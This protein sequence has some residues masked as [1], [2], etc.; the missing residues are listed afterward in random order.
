MKLK[1]Y[2]MMKTRV[3]SLRKMMMMILFGLIDQEVKEM[4]V[5]SLTALTLSLCLRRTRLL[6]KAEQAFLMLL[7]DT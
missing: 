6:L 5:L 2:L 4:T 7:L 3:L 1:V